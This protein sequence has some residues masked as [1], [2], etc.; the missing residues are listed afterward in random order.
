M[1][2]ILN[3]NHKYRVFPAK[4]KVKN[5]HVLSTENAIWNKKI[6]SESLWDAFK[7]QCVLSRL[8]SLYIPRRFVNKTKQSF[9]IER[10]ER[11]L[12]IAISQCAWYSMLYTNLSR[13]VDSICVGPSDPLVEAIFGPEREIFIWNMVFH[14]DM[15]HMYCSMNNHRI[16]HA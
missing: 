10:I 3:Y 5:W 8:F 13:A 9:S 6:A 14:L 2:S 15:T 4:R 16:R 7:M 1:I 12:A 11:M